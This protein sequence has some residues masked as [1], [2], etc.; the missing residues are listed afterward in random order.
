MPRLFTGLEVPADITKLLSALRGGL[1]G[2]RWAE[3]S[4]YHITLRF[5]GDMDTR[6]AREID[7]MLMD[8]DREPL[9]L[10]LTGLG[11]FGGDRPRT[12]IAQ[13]EP[14]R[15]LTELQAEQE[16]L[17]RRM[18]LPADTRKFTPH[19]T[20]ARLRDVST[21]EV[22]RF[23]ATH[24]HIPAR[25]FEARR[26]VIFSARDLVGGGPYVVEAEYPLSRPAFAPAR[27]ARY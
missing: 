14:T 1:P 5:M 2:A 10:T 16:R 11:S 23:L 4:D 20:L 6:R 21:L 9:S 8:V 25:R 7:E 15:A 3:P 22:A 26:F 13:I 17:M 18:G 12:I 27:H 24:G 19:I